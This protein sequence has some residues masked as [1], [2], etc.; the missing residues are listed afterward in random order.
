ML[1]SILRKIQLSK[2]EFIF[3]CIME[4]QYNGGRQKCKSLDRPCGIW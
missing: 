2:S 4:P 3:S 1:S